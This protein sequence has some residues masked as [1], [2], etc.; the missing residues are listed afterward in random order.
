MAPFYT[1][2]LI[3]EKIWPELDGPWQPHPGQFFFGC[4][5][6]DVDKLSPQLTQRDTH[7]FDRSDNYELM[8]SARSTAFLARQETFLSQPFADLPPAA[9]AFAL[10]YLCHLCVDEVS[11]HLWRR[12]LYEQL[13]VGVGRAFAALDEAAR[14]RMQ[15]ETAVADA[16]C[17]IPPLAV[18]PQIPLAD[19]ARLLV[20]ICC[21]M[22]A[23]SVEEQYLILGV[24]DNNSTRRQGRQERF[25][26][27]I[28]R[29]HQQV[30]LFQLEVV[31][32][33]GYRHSHLRLGDLIAGRV[34]EPSYPHI[35]VHHPKPTS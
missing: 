25:R 10:G 2:L 9:Q 33:A 14:Q 34:P 4:L 23:Q 18:I 19:L 32:Q 22:Q 35:K 3:A 13:E 21:F 5:A 12:S 16:L 20:G 1:H 28:E 8:A 7:F 17:T 6:P 27:E 24:L 29:A 11:K 31:I 26:A 15:N 30:H